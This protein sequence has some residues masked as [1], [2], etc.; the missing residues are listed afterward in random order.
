MPKMPSPELPKQNAMALLTET[1][2]P[3]GMGEA[4][5]LTREVAGG[6]LR[7]WRAL[8]AFGLAATLIL[9]TGCHRG[10]SRVARPLSLS[11]FKALGTGI[12]L[13]LSATNIMYAQAS[14]GMGGRAKLYRFSAPPEDCLRYA[15]R[16]ASPGGGQNQALGA[17]S[18]TGLT[19][20]DTRPTPLG[21]DILKAYG[22][23]GVSWFRIDAI[24][25]GYSGSGPPNERGLTWVDTDSGTF[26]YF[27][28]D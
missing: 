28:T 16:L 22:L 6:W 3:L 2:R 20:L 1:H 27:W 15:Q 13:P 7:H 5:C 9:Q 8:M 4:G 24:T 12:D 21:A 14:V 23:E 25:N 10:S 11:A 26:Y 19:K 17:N 18:Q